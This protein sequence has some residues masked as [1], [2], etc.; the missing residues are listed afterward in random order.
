VVF[1]CKAFDAAEAVR[2]TTDLFAMPEV[3]HAA[4]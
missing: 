3:E 2:F 4:F 1:T